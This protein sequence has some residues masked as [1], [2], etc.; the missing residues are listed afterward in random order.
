ML[1]ITGDDIEVVEN[2]I[3]TLEDGRKG[4]ATVAESLQEAGRDDLADAMRR[5]A[6]ERGRMSADL[7]R[8]VPGNGDAD[9]GTVGGALHRSWISLKDALSNNDPH[10][11]LAAAEE[12][13]DHAVEAFEG[14]LESADISSGL[15]A[16]IADQ[17]AS[18][19]AAHDQVRALRDSLA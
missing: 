14:A 4:F 7:Q 11:L 12:G 5:F 1:H 10:A 9:N 17:A 18:V 8:L 19:R 15:R 3:P 13:E 16:V 2:L 6:A